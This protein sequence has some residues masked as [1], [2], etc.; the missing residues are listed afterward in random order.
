[1]GKIMKRGKKWTERERKAVHSERICILMKTRSIRQFQTWWAMGRN[2]DRAM[3][4]LLT[5]AE[6][7]FR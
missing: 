7:K 6:M 1:M 4:E 2:G 3:A 5:V